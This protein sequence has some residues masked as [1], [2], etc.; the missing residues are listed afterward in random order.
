MTTTGRKSGKRRVAPLLYLEEGAAVVVVGSNGGYRRA[1]AWWLNLEA[2]PNAV[3]QIGRE[4]RPV[5]ARK[6]DAAER[7]Q[8]W[9]A[10]VTA[11]A[12]YAAY[13]A[14]TDREIPVVVLD[15]R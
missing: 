8:L 2:D 11:H 1:P 9:A 15:P 14:K 10:F 7:E 5:V 12:G 13:A 6:A 3:V 4:R